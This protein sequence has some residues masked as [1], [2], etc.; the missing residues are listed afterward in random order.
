M[1]RKLRINEGWSSRYS[2]IYDFLNAC[3]FE[4]KGNRYVASFGGHYACWD[5][6]T[7]TGFIYNDV[8]D[9]DYTNLDW[10]EFIEKYYDL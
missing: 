8:E 7:N 6:S 2:D 3:N 1:V 10:E 9:E 5:A 4:K